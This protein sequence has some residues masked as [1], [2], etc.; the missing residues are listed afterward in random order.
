MTTSNTRR[1]F[2]AAHA[3]SAELRE[4][5]EFV[6][7]GELLMPSEELWLVS[8]WVS[9][10]HILDNRGG[11]YDALLPEVGKRQVRLSEILLMLV[12]AGAKVRLVVNDSDHNDA[13]V[14]RL[15]DL[16]REWGVEEHVCIARRDV[17]HT[18]GILT[19]NSVILGSMNVTYR[20]LE[21]NDEV[22]TFDASPDAVADARLNFRNLYAS[23]SESA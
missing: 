17:L 19:S 9:D 1:I 22:V 16:A 4:L 6:F 13:I 7:T 18:K 11:V 14:E 10:V 12:L 2:K 15:G 3:G 20:G 21:I 8:P 23:K 5:L